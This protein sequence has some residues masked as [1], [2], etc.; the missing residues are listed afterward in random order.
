MLAVIGV[1]TL[2]TA[3]GGGDGT[4]TSS[5]DGQGGFAAYQSCLAQHGVTLPSRGQG[6]PRP[7]GDRSPGGSPE[8]GGA[9]PSGAPRGGPGGFMPEGVDRETWRK[10]REACA[11]VLPSDGPGGGPGGFGGGSNSALAAYR[12]CLSEHGVTMSAGPGQLNTADPN[13]AEAEKACAALRP[14]ARPNGGNGGGGDGV[15][16]TP[17]AS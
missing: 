2:V 15:A 16:P 8:G 5:G 9:P 11:S 3:C 14:T 1:A 6:Q 10:A 12:N 7:S 17:A 4:T 13:V